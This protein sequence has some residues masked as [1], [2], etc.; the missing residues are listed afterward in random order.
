MII[1]EI[2]NLIQRCAKDVK[3]KLPHAIEIESSE[4]S[5]FPRIRILRSEGADQ[6][7]SLVAKHIINFGLT[8]LPIRNQPSETQD[9]VLTYVTQS[10]LTAE[11]IQAVEDSKFWTDS[12]KYPLLLIRGLL[13]GGVLRFCFT[14][15]RWRVQY[16]LDTTRTPATKLAVPYRSKDSPSPRSEFSHPDVVIL[17]SLLSYYYGGL[18]DDELFDSLAHLSKSDQAAIQYSE[19]VNTASPA[20][21]NGFRHLSGVSIKDR[22]QCITEVFPALR[23]SKN[24]IDYFLAHLV[25]PKEMKGF[26]YKLSASGWDLG[27]V[28]THPTTGFSGTKDTYHVLPLDVKHLDMP[29]QSHTN[30]LVLGYLLD[31]AELKMLP[32]RTNVQITDAEHLLAIVNTLGPDV[33]VVLDV[34]AQILELDNFQVAEKWL[35]MRKD[36]RTQAVVYFQDEELSILD[37]TGRV[38]SFQTSPFAK[39]LDLCLVYLDEAH[40]RGTDLRLPRNY[41]AAVTLGANLTKDRLVQACMRMRQL[42]KGQS[43]VCMIPEE[44]SSKI[45]DRME[46]PDTPIEVSDVLCWSVGESWMD[47]KR[48]MPLWAVQGHRFE[49]HKNLLN[50]ANTTLE[51]ANSFLE[52][53]AQ[54]L[55]D[56][57]KPRVQGD[58]SSQQLKGWDM[59]NK[60]I[61]Q[62]VSRCRDFEAMSFNSATL[63]EEQEVSRAADSFTKPS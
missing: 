32:P 31:V 5:R 52:A 25:F 11:Q 15:K 58:T 35:S 61:A 23:Y 40:T 7:L 53:E 17:L 16:G 24:A 9:A 55:E 56:R 39:Q 49:E 8:S 47:L 19:W 43:V 62:I 3:G 34:G 14:S 59:S 27:A 28:K 44:I 51:Q 60:K 46:N 29:S 22:H 6:L 57:Y 4:E 10:E 42:G 33:R 63:Q 54:G 18:S 26:P 36:E 50:G 20:L 48:S 30:A 2:L 41:R 21:S 45:R 38:E 1:Q 37:S 12:T 13:A